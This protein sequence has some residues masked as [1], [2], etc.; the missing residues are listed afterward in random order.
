MRRRKMAELRVRLKVSNFTS[1][2]TQDERAFNYLYKQVRHDFLLGK[3]IDKGPN[4][5]KEDGEETRDVFRSIHD[6]IYP[7][8]QKA[9]LDDEKRKAYIAKLA[10]DMK[11]IALLMTVDIREKLGLDTNGKNEAFKEDKPGVTIRDS[12]LSKMSDY[13]PQGYSHFGKMERALEKKGLTRSASKLV[14][15]W[16][17]KNE[18]SSSMKEAFLN[19]VTQ[20]HTS[21][22]SEAFSANQ[23]DLLGG[24]RGGGHPVNGNC[25]AIPVQITVH[26][27]HY[28]ERTRAT[29]EPVIVANEYQDG[30]AKKLSQEYDVLCK[31][32][33]IVNVNFSVENVSIHICRQNGVP[34]FLRMESRQEAE[35]FLTL[36]CA[37]YRL[38]EKWMFV[39]CDEIRFPTLDFLQANN[40]HGPES[41]EFVAE[42]YALS[43]KSNLKYKE[44]GTYLIRQCDKSPELFIIHF[45][46]STGGF[47]VI[48]VRITLRGTFRVKSPF[49]AEFDNMQELVRTLHKKKQFIVEVPQL[50]GCLRPSEY[51][52]TPNLL[53]CR[54][55]Q[56][57]KET[58]SRK[59]E[60]IALNELKRVENRKLAGSGRYSTTHKG[61]WTRRRG[62]GAA[63]AVDVAIRRVELMEAE[64]EFMEMI[65]SFV[66][67]SGPTL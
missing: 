25:A 56:G 55:A 7:T 31:I 49:E 22:F 9:D 11:N 39:L 43:A 64:H 16:L 66:R 19:A 2:L 53:L 27:S 58:T 35:S 26:H 60:F 17:A 36:I 34:V 15:K 14:D 40:V 30:D 29:Q 48:D 54:V 12:V 23:T 44:P 37:Y 45:R 13:W 46:N 33:E 42:K 50:K 1:L 32:S 24:H 21:Y 47:G 57:E 3:L 8:P 67:A 52:K 61:Q 20:H 65:H 28:D 6:R 51:D 63:A 5:K 10:V 41:F 59:P 62:G 38:Q 18:L 4:E